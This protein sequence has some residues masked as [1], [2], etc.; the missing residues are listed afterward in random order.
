MANTRDSYVKRLSVPRP[1]CLRERENGHVTPPPPALVDRRP[2]PARCVPRWNAILASLRPPTLP[3]LSPWPC[4]QLDSNKT[5]I[6]PQRGCVRPGPNAGL[7]VTRTPCLG[8]RVPAFVQT[9]GPS[10]MAEAQESRSGAE[11]TRCSGGKR[12]PLLPPI[13][14]SHTHRQQGI[15]ALVF[16]STAP[17]QWDGDNVYCTLL[18]A[19]LERTSAATPPPRHRSG[20]S[21]ILTKSE[22]IKPGLAGSLPRCVVA[23]NLP[24]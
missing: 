3:P 6:L 10:L 1:R 24:L 18:W 5:P 12:F 13:P 22:F 16:D 2:C 17:L 21:R 11:G 9:P 20:S 14:L 15:L 19:T 23:S 4:Y 8:L 7:C